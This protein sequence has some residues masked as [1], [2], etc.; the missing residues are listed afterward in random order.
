MPVEGDLPNTEDRDIAVLMEQ[1]RAGEPS[2]AA[3]VFHRFT[4]RLIGL[5]RSRL[6]LR[7]RRKVDPEDVVQS[8]FDSFFRAQSARTMEF[9]DWNSL[10]GL[11]TQITIRKCGHRFRFFHRARR[12]VDE[13]RSVVAWEGESARAWEA[14]AREPTPAEGAA[15][16]ETVEELVQSLDDRERRIFTMYLE[17]HTVEQIACNINRSERTVRRVLK[18]IQ[19]QLERRCFGEDDR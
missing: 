17:S 10:W 9:V 6:N 16:T 11:L 12:N 4:H 7:L 18:R 2:A 5:A 14:I 8:V 19:Q 3:E 15:L 1:L 13:E